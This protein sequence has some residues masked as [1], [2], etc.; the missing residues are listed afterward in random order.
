MPN[1]D[2]P[3]PGTADTIGLFGPDTSGALHVER[4][5]TQEG[6]HPF[7]EVEWEHRHASI[8]AENGEVIFEADDVEMPAAWSQLATNV[9]VSKYFRVAQG[10]REKSLRALIVRVVATISAWGLQDGYFQSEAERDIFADELTHLLLYQKAAFNSPVWFNVGVEAE[11]QCSAC[12]INSVQ[13]TMDSILGL[14][15]TEGML[16]KFGSG[17]GTNFSSLRGSKERLSSG[18]FASGPVSFM[19]GFDAF[20]GVIKSGG[21]TR[22]AAK[23][24]ILNIDHPDIHEFIWCKAHEEQKAWALIEAGYDGSFGGEAYASVMFQ[25]SNNSVRVT[26]DFMDAVIRDKTWQTR[27]VVGGALIETFRARELMRELAEAAHLCG[28]PGMQFDTTVNDWNT[29]PNSGRINASNPCSE[30]MFLDDSACNLSSL[31]LMRFRKPNGD[32]DVESFRRASAIM[33][34]AQEIIVDR[35]A[36]PTPLITTNAKQYRPLGLGYANLGALLMANGLAYDSDEGRAL[37]AAITAI[38][39]GQGYLTSAQIASR[40]GPFSDYL[41]NRDPFMRVM[42]KH[43]AQVD[44]IERLRSVRELI[45]AARAVWDEAIK[46]G[47]QY[48]Y[49]NS[50]VSLLAPTGTIGFMMDCD[51]TGVEPD[52]ALVKYKKLSGGGMFKIVNLTVPMA[53]KNLGYSEAQISEM[54]HYIEQHDTIEG[55]PGLKDE[56]LPVFDCA[57]KPANGLRSIHY[58]GHL[59]MMAAVQP[60]LSGAI[61]KTVNLGKDTTADEIMDIYIEAWRL[62]LK[63]VAIYRDGSKRT[64]PLTTKLDSGEQATADAPATE[65]KPVRRRLP[66]ERTAITHK[67]SIAGHEGYLTVGLFEDGQPG[68]IFIKM[69]KQGSVVSGLMDSFAIAIS[70]SLQYGVPLQTLVDKFSHSRFEPSGWTPNPEIPMAKSIVDYL[71]RWL[72]IKFLGDT[73]DLYVTRT[74]PALNGSEDGEEALDA[75]HAEPA[76]PP[77]GFDNQSDAP[78]CHN[79]GE[80]MVRNGACY[81]CLNCGSTSGCS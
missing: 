5:F 48:G 25:N 4:Y 30:F 70:M 3:L 50:Q 74:K 21:R 64:Q 8:V 13:D 46:M 44:R 32:F 1:T 43:R 59:R 2:L 78:P 27:G 69:S 24:V 15:R 11:P 40:R 28:D 63:A 42:Q 62:G 14:A 17:T 29:C 55:A 73:A 47:E 66:D 9:V 23:M 6:V 26:D 51:T 65:Y 16:F 35:A 18:G 75:R 61:S 10:N 71:F 81:K 56:H 58:M 68:E 79:C 7:D 49:R 38:M 22:R 80:I 60:F 41:Q 67:F 37:A 33:I 77:A 20:A 12:F 76:A 19:R 54:L 34:L 72:A 52:I 31:N 36:Y 45:K 57:F 39:T 53:L